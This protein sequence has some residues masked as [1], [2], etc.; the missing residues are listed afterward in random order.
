MIVGAGSVGSATARLLSNRGDEVRLVSRSGSGPD[1]PRVTRVAADATDQ[2]A[3]SRV[4]Q[5]A[6][7]IY[8]CAN[9][10]Y[11]RWAT[12]WP[13]LALSILETAISIH[14]VQVTVN[15]LYA[16]GPLDHPMT[17]DDPLAPAG[18]KGRIRAKMWTDA[19]AAH[20]AGRVKVT[21]ARASDY[22]GPGLTDTS[23]LGS[24]V[25][26]RIL[27]GRTV[28]VLGDPDAPHSWTYVPDVARTL[29][30]LATDPRAWG[31]A[32]H[33]P[34]APPQSQRQVITTMAA[35]AGAPVPHVKSVPNWMIRLGGLFSPVL[36]Q[37]PEVMYQFDRPFV[38]DSTR[39]SATFGVQPTP[40][41]Q[42]LAATV[43]WWKSRALRSPS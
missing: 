27:H 41:P 30:V 14:A 33:V 4:S 29:I 18:N 37:L 43:D 13:P 15:N 16:Y 8:N 3:L 38:L 25:V 24:R 5:G 2:S 10:P 9:P 20:Q 1:E 23:H 34:T 36:R 42:A 17:E 21:E 19:L 11:H 26:P 40:F 22:F 31:R 6:V 32:W 7:A 35:L 12:D 28:R 39:A